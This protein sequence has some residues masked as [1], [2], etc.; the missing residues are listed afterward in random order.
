M[1]QVRKYTLRTSA[2]NTNPMIS[3]DE[4]HSERDVE[5]IWYNNKYVLKSW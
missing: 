3:A 2:A 4:A 5:V 1:M